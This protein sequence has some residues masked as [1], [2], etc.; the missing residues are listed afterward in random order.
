MDLTLGSLR[1][2]LTSQTPPSRPFHTWE[3]AVLEGAPSETLW[4]PEYRAG[5]AHMGVRVARSMILPD[6][7]TSA[8][9]RSEGP[10][11]TVRN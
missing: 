4:Q 3:R 5:Q 9:A 8:R 7:A 11:A 6:T 2:G 1:W 10:E